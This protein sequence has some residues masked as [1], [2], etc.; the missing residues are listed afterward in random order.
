M[1]IVVSLVSVYFTPGLPHSLDLQQ[2]T[3][4]GVQYDSQGAQDA[5][6]HFQ[7]TVR[8]KK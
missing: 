7:D 1:F 5:L 8:E 6:Q 4:P 3:S 2:L